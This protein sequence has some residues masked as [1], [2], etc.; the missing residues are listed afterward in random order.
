MART[1]HKFQTVIEGTKWVEPMFT[2]KGSKLSRNSALNPMQL[3]M[4]NQIA[5][6]AK[7]ITDVPMSMLSKKLNIQKSVRTDNVVDMGSGDLQVLGVCMI[8][9]DRSLQM[10]DVL[11]R[12]AHTQCLMMP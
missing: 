6:L 7:A 5:Q 2:A 4:V 8:Y 1:G 3:N 12:F 11:R 9:V 10:H